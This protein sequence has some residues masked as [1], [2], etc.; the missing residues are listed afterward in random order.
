[1]VVGL[2][3]LLLSM[4][5]LNKPGANQGVAASSAKYSLTV[6]TIDN[7]AMGLS[8]NFNKSAPMSSVNVIAADQQKPSQNQDNGKQNKPANHSGN[9]KLPAQAASHTVIEATAKR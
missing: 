7:S 3:L 6:A 8:A 5:L 2:G 9:D 4:T 1:M